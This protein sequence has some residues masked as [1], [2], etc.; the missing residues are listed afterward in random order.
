VRPVE[1]SAFV[2]VQTQDVGDGVDDSGGGRG[3]ALRSIT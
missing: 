2:I 3:A 1:V